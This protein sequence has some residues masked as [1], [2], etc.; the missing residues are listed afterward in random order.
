MKPRERTQ[1]LLGLMQNEGIKN[2]IEL[3][4]R[5]GKS[6]VAVQ[7]IARRYGIT[8]ESFRGQ[9]LRKIKRQVQKKLRSGGT[10]AV[11]PDQAKE[12]IVKDSRYYLVLALAYKRVDEHINK[13][14]S[15]FP[16][17]AGL[18]RLKTDLKQASAMA[19]AK[20]LF[21]ASATS[22]EDLVE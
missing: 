19:E 16:N 12:D 15:E 5:T 2:P 4:I 10:T 22:V 14:S 3:S 21:S 7:T 11:S 9:D 13:L 18:D 17:D 20:V 1:H 8:L 6:V